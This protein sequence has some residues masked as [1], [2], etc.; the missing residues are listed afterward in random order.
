MYTKNDKLLNAMITHGGGF[1]KSLARTMQVADPINYN[2]LCK[3]FPD[4]VRHY[5]QI[6]E[7]EE[8]NTPTSNA[9]TH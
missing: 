8:K 1:V 6:V 5:T 7:L 3:A 9:N 2:K 4:I